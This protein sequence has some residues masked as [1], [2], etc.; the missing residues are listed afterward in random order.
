MKSIPLICFLAVIMSGSIKASDNV[1]IYSNS[2]KTSEGSYIEESVVV[3]KSILDAQLVTD[4]WMEN[5]SLTPDKAINLA[6]EKMKE[7]DPLVVR[8][9]IQALQ[10]RLTEHPKNKENNFL[11]GVPFYVIDVQGFRNP[12]SRPKVYT[13]TFI[14]LPDGSVWNTIAKK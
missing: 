13:Q 1:Q 12:D 10:L 5:P 6:Q 2:I 7:N 3:P 4:L 8:T 9:H 14:V 11:I